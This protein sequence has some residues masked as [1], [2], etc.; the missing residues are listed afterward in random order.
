MRLSAASLTLLALV[1]SSSAQYFSAGWTPGQP[2]KP[3]VQQATATYDPSAAP[4]HAAEGSPKA[5]PFSLS[6]L[7][8]VDKLLTSEPAVALFSKF[9]INITER[10]EAAVNQKIW[11][12][13]VELITDDNYEDLIVNES[14]TAEEEQKRVWMIVM[15]V[16]LSG[17][18]PS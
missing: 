4:T 14:L 6:N 9:G 5:T 2:G 13:R 10:V 12:D 11:D 18:H 3:A 17:S 7:F 16:L 15:C 8:N 1:G